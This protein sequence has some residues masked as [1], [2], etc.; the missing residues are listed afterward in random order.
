[1]AG[2]PVAG[3]TGLNGGGE[4]GPSTTLP[5]EAGLRPEVPNF[6]DG[7]STAVSSQPSG[8]EC[9]FEISDLKGG[10]PATLQSGLAAAGGDSKGPALALPKRKQ[11][12]LSVQD[13]NGGEKQRPQR[14]AVAGRLCGEAGP[15]TTLGVS[16]GV[17]MAKATAV[18]CGGAT[19]R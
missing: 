8:E 4:A 11:V 7:A 1:M 18:S 13:D 3:A 15:S 19:L 14:E 17:E 10:R 12:L 16:V 5:P 9:R 2:D 6:R